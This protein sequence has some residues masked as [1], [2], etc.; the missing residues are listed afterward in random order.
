M[1]RTEKKGGHKAAASAI[2]YI[3][4][5]ACA[6]LVVIPILYMVLS[7]FKNPSEVNKIVSLPSGLYLENFKSVFQNSVAVRSFL[8]SIVV[9]VATITI[10][11][12]LCSL[13]AYAIGR[14]KEKYFSFLYMLF[15]SAM[16]IPV[17]ANLPAI[18]NIIMKFH[19][20][21]T[22]TSLVLIYAATQIPMGILL[23]TGFIKGIPVE[24][25]EAAI[26]DGCGYLKRFQAII[27]PLLKPVVVT[28]ALTSIVSV[29]NDFLM[30]LMMISSES[31]KPITLAVYSFVNEHQSDYGAIFAM[32]VVAM[33]PPIILFVALQKHFYE[34]LAAGAVKG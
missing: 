26:I 6:V 7:A 16:M 13:A 29:W 3:F 34:G 25:D 32:L 20:K 5:Y 19:L 17:V 12:A 18:Y 8:N 2:R 31:K 14:R 30:P 15:L 33:L 21:D 4:T 9:S 24:M 28:Y 27:F 22:R 11:I 10:D 23:F 1:K